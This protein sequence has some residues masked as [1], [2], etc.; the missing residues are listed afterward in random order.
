MATVAM[1]NKKRDRLADVY[2]SKVDIIAMTVGAFVARYGGHYD[3]LR[4]D[5]D[6]C[7]L[8]CC[9]KYGVDAEDF[10]SRLKRWVWFGLFDEYRT[11]AGLRRQVNTQLYGDMTPVEPYYEDDL[12]ALDKYA[13][14][15]DDAQACI[16]LALDPPD[17]LRIKAGQRGGRPQNIRS[18]MREHLHGLGWTN[19]R[20]ST[21]FK[22]VKHAL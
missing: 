13:D 14:L 22:E 10:D 12:T 9:D 8:L 19:T 15:S 2:T 5:A 16:Y 21:A 18:T 7:F 1:T 3:T 17:E 11:T 20:V 4:T 6:L